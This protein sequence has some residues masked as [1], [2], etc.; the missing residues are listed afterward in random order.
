MAASGN[1]STLPNQ[2][3]LDCSTVKLIRS[4]RRRNDNNKKRIPIDFDQGLKNA[5]IVWEL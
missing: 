2:F 1:G 4:R 3:D 5:P